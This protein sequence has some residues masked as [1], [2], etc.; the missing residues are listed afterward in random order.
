[1]I[2]ARLR[3]APATSCVD[4][5]RTASL[6]THPP[7]WS[8]LA[9]PT[10]ETRIEQHARFT[11]FAARQQADRRRRQAALNDHP[12]GTDWCPPHGIP[13]PDGAA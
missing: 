11:L 6:T 5:A 13:R 9:G 4:D 12:A 10:F 3:P 8:G 1:M 7:V 2:A